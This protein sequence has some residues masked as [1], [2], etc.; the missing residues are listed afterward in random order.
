MESG[1]IMTRQ[2][3]GFLVVCRF[4]FVF[5]LLCQGKGGGRHERGAA[6]LG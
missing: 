4:S 3:F 1:V 5:T 6:K 2:I